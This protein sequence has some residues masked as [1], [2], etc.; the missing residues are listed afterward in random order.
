KYDEAT[1]AKKLRDHALF[2][3]FAP[4]ENPK[5]AI[6]VIAENGSHGSSVAAPISRL[7]IDEWL[8]I[9]NGALPE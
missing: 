9:H 8:R 1:I 6:A 2:I 4:Y 3:S 5:I 7:I